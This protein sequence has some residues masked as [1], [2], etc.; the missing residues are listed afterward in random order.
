MFSLRPLT[1][2]LPSREDKEHPVVDLDLHLPL[3]CFRS[4]QLLQVWGGF[5]SR[6]PACHGDSLGFVL[7]ETSEDEKVDT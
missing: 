6:R 3:L 4:T 5:S 2:V 1:I 7:S